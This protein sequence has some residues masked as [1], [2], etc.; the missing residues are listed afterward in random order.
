MSILLEKEQKYNIIVVKNWQNFPPPKKTHIYF[1]LL[2][3]N[4]PSHKIYS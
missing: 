3:S 2:F 1:F 4:I